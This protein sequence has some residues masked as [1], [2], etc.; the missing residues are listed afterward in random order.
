VSFRNFIFSKPAVGSSWRA[1]CLS[2]FSVMWTD[3]VQN[4]IWFF[5]IDLTAPLDEKLDDEADWT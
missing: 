3:F 2:T 5:P 4:K 1:A